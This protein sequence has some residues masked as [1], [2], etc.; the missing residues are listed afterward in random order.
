[1]A[2][3]S[4]SLQCSCFTFLLVSQED[5]SNV[6]CLM[7]I[8]LSY[9]DQGIIYG[10]DRPVYTENILTWFGGKVCPSL[11][12][13]PKLFIFQVFLYFLLSDWFCIASSFGFYMFCIYLTTELTIILT[14][15]LNF[16]K[17]LNHPICQKYT[18]DSRF[19]SVTYNKN[20]RQFKYLGFYFLLCNW[21]A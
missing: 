4:T 6:D 5:H 9:G 19:I 16:K 12:G 21:E 3:K 18:R 20:P 11:A 1:M 10:S 14:K 13:K 2:L 17:S 15:S 8:I 7:C